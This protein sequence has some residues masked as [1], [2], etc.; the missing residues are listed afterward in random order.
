MVN[1]ILLSS[2]KSARVIG[3]FNVDTLKECGTFAASQN[4]PSKL[5]WLAQVSLPSAL[6][7]GPSSA[8][9]MVQ[10]LHNELKEVNRKIL[11]NELDIPPEGE[12]SPSPEP[13]Y[14]RNGVRLN[15]REVSR[16]CFFV[17]ALAFLVRPHA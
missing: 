10:R 14:D 3:S 17:I 5:A 2:S 16:L 13:M 4:W 15:T 9:P 1:P 6:V 8:D 7:G 11:N 12:R